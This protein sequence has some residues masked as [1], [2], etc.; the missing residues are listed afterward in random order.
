MKYFL[1]PLL[2][3]SLS[4]SAQSLDYVK[5]F[6]GNSRIVPVDLKIDNSGNTYIGGYFLDEVDFDPSAALNIIRSKGLGDAFVLKLDNQ[7]NLIWVNVYGSVGEDRIFGVA[8]DKNGDLYVTGG[9]QNTID[10]NPNGSNGAQ[11]SNGDYDIFAL[12]LDQNGNFKK[13]VSIGGAIIDVI[14]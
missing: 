9:F 10:F 7:G 8:F 1:I 13:V 11:T 2:L 12:K 6:N 5:K 3:L 14:S 4:F